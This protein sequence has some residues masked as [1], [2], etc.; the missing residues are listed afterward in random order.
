MTEVVPPDS[1][2][3]NQI[4]AE[5][6]LGSGGTVRERRSVPSRWRSEGRSGRG[7][8]GRT[9]EPD[10]A[11]AGGE[12]IDGRRAGKRVLF[13]TSPVVGSMRN[14]WLSRAP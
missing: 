8:R 12:T 9:P 5:H 10:A 2:Q 3:P 13:V 14:S 11:K 7:S 4:A 1:D 6:H